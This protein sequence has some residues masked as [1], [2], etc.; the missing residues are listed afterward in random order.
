MRFETNAETGGSVAK[1]PLLTMPEVAS[2]LRCSKGHISNLIAGKVNGV[3]RLPALTLGRRKLVRQSTLE[4]W[5]RAA[6]E[7]RDML[8]PSSEMSAGRMEG[9]FRA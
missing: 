6:E 4:R 7:G 5:K 9:V 8:S 2:E 3:P 1:D